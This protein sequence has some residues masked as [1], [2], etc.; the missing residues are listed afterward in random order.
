M[1]SR[2][3]VLGELAIAQEKFDDAQS[4]F[5]ARRP[6]F[7]ENMAFYRGLQ[8][9]ESTP[10]G[11]VTLPDLEDE[12]TR[13]VNNYVRPTVRSAAA[14]RFRHTPRIEVVPSDTTTRARV[15]AEASAG[16]MRAAMRSKVY[17][18]DEQLR[19][20]LAAAIHGGAFA[21]VYWDPFEGR[22]VERLVVDPQDPTQSRSETYLPGMPKIRFRDLY[23]ALPDS[24]ARKPEDILHVFERKMLARSTLDDRFP[25]DVF[26]RSTRAAW[27]YQSNRSA[28]RDRDL[29]EDDGHLSGGQDER[30][31]GPNS[32]FELVEYWEKPTL[33]YPRGRLIVWCGSAV[34][35][36]GPAPYEFPWH[37]LPGENSMPSSLISDGVVR[38]LKGPQRSINHSATLRR[39]WAGKLMAPAVLNPSNSGIRASEFTDRLGAV[40]DYNPGGKPS[41]LTPPDLPPSISQ[42]E[43]VYVQTIKTVSTYSEISRGQAPSGIRSGRGV[44]FLNELEEQVRAPDHAI[45]QTFMADV[46]LAV[47]RLYRDFAEEGQVVEIVGA[48][49]DWQVRP[50]RRRDYDFDAVVKIEP[51][52]TKPVSRSERFSEAMEMAGVQAFSDTPEA[53]RFRRVV[54]VDTEETSADPDRVHRMRV[55]SEHDALLRAAETSDY[56]IT[57]EGLVVEGELAVEFLEE[58]DHEVHAEEDD[59]FMVSREFRRLPLELKAFYREHKLLHEQVSLQQNAL[60]AEEAGTLAGP[61][62]GPSGG[63]PPPSPPG[64]PSPSDGGNP[65]PAESLNAAESVYGA[66]E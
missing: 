14:A 51:F 48:N 15:I 27:G 49:A 57:P 22:A 7:T 46:L 43:D 55:L 64:R 59:I 45:Y 42:M 63:P 30:Q 1:P 39:E 66:E 41:Y 26:G 17:P 19:V 60:F 29:I 13:E 2:E 65:Q 56:Q 8:W 3:E 44:G 36:Y 4:T 37:F 18:P 50:F 40:L 53:R 25:K 6:D 33:R 9:G 16:L 54:G 24:N 58:D 38:D 34:L 10:F 20:I 61:S 21:K 32:T 5:E 28:Y 12:V 52:A 31:S 62:Q 11:F 47:L 35:A 23:D